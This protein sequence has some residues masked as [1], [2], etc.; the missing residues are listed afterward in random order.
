[1]RERIRNKPQ[2]VFGNQFQAIE[3]VHAISRG[4]WDRARKSCREPRTDSQ[5]DRE[6]AYRARNAIEIDRLVK[7]NTGENWWWLNCFLCD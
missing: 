7:A 3:G 1:M 2:S 4:G 5:C 6:E